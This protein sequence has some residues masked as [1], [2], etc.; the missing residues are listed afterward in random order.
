MNGWIVAAV[1]LP[2]LIVL[3][4]VWVASRLLHQSGSIMLRISTLETY[5]DDLDDAI[6]EVMPPPPAEGLATGSDAPAFELPD[7][8]GRRVSLQ[9][10]RGRRVLLI[11]FSPGCGFCQAMAPSLGR[12][13]LGDGAPVPV[14]ITNGDADANRALVGEHGIPFPVLLQESDEVSSVYKAAGTPMGCLIDEQG[15]IASPLLV[16]AEDLLRL[17]E[18]RSHA[19]NGNGAGA[20]GADANPS[21]VLP[22][23]VTWQKRTGLRPGARA[24]YF[25]LPRL[26]GG[27]LSLKEFLGRRVLLVFSDPDCPAC[28]QVM[29]AL[30]SLYGRSADFEMIVISR[31]APDENRAKVSALG[32]TAPVGLQRGNDISRLYR[33]LATPAA[34]LIDE[35]GIIAAPSAVGGEILRLAALAAGPRPGDAPAPMT[36]RG[37]DLASGGT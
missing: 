13:E 27:R 12:L 37:S 4:G 10:F 18:V 16:G 15:L 36:W 8:E 26:G 11:F 9:Q 32:I 1:V 30:Q 17:T 23:R 14:V 6:R 2:W 20:P 33:K 35:E 25:L 5:L 24:P 7:L 28:D 3:V 19:G 31:G 22:R 34:Y 21:E 29:P